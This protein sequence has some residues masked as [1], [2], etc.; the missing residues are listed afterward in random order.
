MGQEFLH[1][2]SRSTRKF[3]FISPLFSDV[4]ASIPVSEK[5]ASDIFSHMA[6][7][8]LKS[9]KRVQKGSTPGTKK[10]LFIHL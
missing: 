4:L 9:D 7:E 6:L 5:W 10:V 3:D 1:F 8:L 2:F